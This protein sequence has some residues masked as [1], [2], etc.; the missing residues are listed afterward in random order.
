[1]CRYIS[2][3]CLCELCADPIVSDAAQNSSQQP[4]FSAQISEVI[5]IVLENEDDLD[6]QLVALHILQDLLSKNGPSFEEQFARLGLPNKILLLAKNKPSDDSES[7]AGKDETDA[8]AV[9]I[10]KG[11][12]QEESKP[13][14]SDS[15]GKVSMATDGSVESKKGLLLVMM[16]I[17]CGVKHMSQCH[18]FSHPYT[19]PTS[20]HV[21]VPTYSTYHTPLNPLSTLHIYF[22]QHTP[23]TVHI[24]HF[25]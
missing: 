17:R 21:T 14:I 9:A 22:T 15:E 11:R 13:A 23:H 4:Q 1:M 6:G 5:A 16:R 8:G 2:P 20:P 19:L 12:D 3:E 7:E 24:A 25:T 18:C 10:E